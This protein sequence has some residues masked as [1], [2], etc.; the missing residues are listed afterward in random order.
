MKSKQFPVVRPVFLPRIGSQ[1]KL[2]NLQPLPKKLYLRLS[3]ITDIPIAELLPWRLDHV[4]MRI[5]VMGYAASYLGF[6][7]GISQP[8]L[9]SLTHN[10]PKKVGPAIF[11]KQGFKTSLGQH[12]QLHSL[13]SI[14]GAEHRNTLGEHFSNVGSRKTAQNN[15]YPELISPINGFYH[16]YGIDGLLALF[17]VSK[18]LKHERRAAPKTVAELAELLQNAAIQIKQ[19]GYLSP[20]GF[21][22]QGLDWFK[23]MVPTKEVSERITRIKTAR[24]GAGLRM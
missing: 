17:A 8:S 19:S 15:I 22:R 10:D 9:F 11:L 4:R 6:L 7:H 20:Q 24:K 5:D 21:T 18:N 3:Q 23:Q 1:Y 13:C 12:E 14:M 2:H 16:K